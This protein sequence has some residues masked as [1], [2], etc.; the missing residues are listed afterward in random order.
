MKDVDSLDLI[1]LNASIELRETEVICQHI[2]E[3][4]PE[5]QVLV[6]TKPI[7][8]TDKIKMAEPWGK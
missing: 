5:K 8:V 2:N 1:I 3:A 7:G 4:I 6:L